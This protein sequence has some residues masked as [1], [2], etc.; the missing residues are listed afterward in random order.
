MGGI[1]LPP[2]ALLELVIPAVVVAEGR[3]VEERALTEPFVEPEGVLA[4][5]LDGEQHRVGEVDLRLLEV[6]PGLLERLPGAGL[7]AE[8]LDVDRPRD[9]EQLVVRDGDPPAL[10]LGVV[11]GEDVRTHAHQ[12]TPQGGVEAVRRGD[13]H[14]H[15]RCL[16]RTHP[17]IDPG[18]GEG[19]GTARSHPE[20]AGEA[21]ADMREA[22]GALLMTDRRDRAA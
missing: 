17:R 1:L 10:P 12:C 7:D 9:L 5:A 19:V 15:L 6:A 11:H 18:G 13:G 22:N 14:G 2:R 3:E 8:E 16:A 4:D 21:R 20:L